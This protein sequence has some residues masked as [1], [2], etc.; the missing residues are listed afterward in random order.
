ML[1]HER[2]CVVTV[3]VGR[4][5]TTDTPVVINNIGLLHKFHGNNI[6]LNSGIVSQFVGNLDKRKSLKDITNCA[7]IIRGVAPPSGFLSHSCSSHSRFFRPRGS[8]E[9]MNECLNECINEYMNELK[10]A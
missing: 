7:R 8:H 9:R 5:L 2:D 3:P 10:N 1:N 6:T 4:M